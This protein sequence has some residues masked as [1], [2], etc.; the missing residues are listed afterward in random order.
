MSHVALLGVAILCGIVLWGCLILAGG[1]V[2]ELQN[3]QLSL[4]QVMHFAY[5]SLKFGLA[6]G[7]AGI[8]ALVLIDLL[9]GNGGANWKIINRQIYSIGWP[10]ALIS[11]VALNIVK[12]YSSS[13]K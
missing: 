10:K 3:A 6:L 8:S 1:V 7:G 11:F 13:S 2:L 4:V 5:I 12:E 9:G